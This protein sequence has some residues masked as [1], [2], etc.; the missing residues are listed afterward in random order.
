MVVWEVRV[1]WYSTENVVI[2]IYSNCALAALAAMR[3]VNEENGRSYTN[4]DYP[5]MKIRWEHSWGYELFYETYYDYLDFCI[6]FERVTVNDST[7]L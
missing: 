7:F 1:N 5:K 2:G 3:Y 4:N 6:I